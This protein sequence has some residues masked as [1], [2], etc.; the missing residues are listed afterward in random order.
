MPDQQPRP[1]EAAFSEMYADREELIHDVQRIIDKVLPTYTRDEQTIIEFTAF[2]ESGD[3][4]LAAINEAARPAITMFLA[5]TGLSTNDVETTLDFSSTFDIADRGSGIPHK[6]D[7]AQRL[8]PY[9]TDRLTT[10]LHA[11]TVI[12]QTT[13]RWTVD[14]RRHYRKDFEKE[15][16]THL[17]DKGIPLLPDTEVAGAPDIA[18]P[19]NNDKMAVVGEIRSSNKQDLGTRVREFK[20]EIRHLAELHPDAKIV[21]VIE[22][23]E[24][25]PTERY[26]SMKQDFEDSVGEQLSG[27]YSGTDIAKLA[28]D[29]QRWSPQLQKPIQSY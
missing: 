7:R 8:A 12:Q 16:Q 26:E 14:H 27:I 23:A 11:E 3:T 25:I 5:V 9:L 28:V 18:V 24:E 17:Q 10:D 6:D 22:F 2:D 20:S 21:I 19:E 29:C 1:G 13:L 15:V 4:V